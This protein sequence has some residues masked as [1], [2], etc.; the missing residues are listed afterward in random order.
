MG[1]RRV[2]AVSRFEPRG[3]GSFRAR[4]AMGA[5]SRR[6]EMMHHLRKRSPKV[7][8]LYGATCP[9]VSEPA[10]ISPSPRRRVDQRE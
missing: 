7:T 10:S 5:W 2:R 4:A 3:N 1:W 9:L 6:Q 8:W